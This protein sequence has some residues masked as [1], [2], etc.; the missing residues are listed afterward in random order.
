[1][2]V[3]SSQSL[4]PDGVGSQGKRAPMSPEGSRELP[5]AKRSRLPDFASATDAT[6]EWRATL[7]ELAPAIVALRVTGCRAF[8][9]DAAAS[10]L[11]T[12]FVVDKERGLILT[13]R[14]V[15]GVGPVRALAIFDRHE[16]L[17]VEVIYRDPVHDFGFFRFDPSKLRMTRRHEVKLDPKGLLVGTE[18]R[19][20]GN[21]AGEKLQILSGT[22]ARVDRN[23]PEF[24]TAYNDE[25]TFYAGAGAGTSG[26]SSGS[27]VVNKQGDAIALNAAGQEG[28]AAAYF[29]PLDRVVYTLALLQADKA[30]PRGTIMA[31]F[32]FQ[33]FD[34]LKRLGLQHQAE[35]E[36]REA[37]SAATGMLIAYSVACEQTLLRSGD[38]LLRLQDQICDNFVQLESVLDAHVGQTVKLRVC[39]L[40][41]E[42]DL[43]VPVRDFHALTPRS[44][45]ELGLDVVH[46]IGYHVAKKVHLPLDSGVYLA[47]SGYVFDSLGCGRASIIV[48]VNEKPTP[49]LK[50]FVEAFSTIADRECFPVTWYE[51]ADFRRD[52][53]LRTGFAKMSRSWSPM[54]LWHCCGSP[55]RP[56][57][58]SPT[59]L[60]VPTN[61]KRPTVAGPSAYF[62]T[63]AAPVLRKLQGSLVTVR[64]R[65]DRRFCTEAGLAGS[66]EGVGLIVDA[67]KGLVLTDRHSAPQSLG[68]VE[69][70]LAG[71]TTVDA[72]VVFIHPLHN[73]AILRYD[74]ASLKKAKL[75]VQSAKLSKGAKAFLRPGEN[76]FFAGYDSQGNSFAA[77]VTV[78]AVYLPSGRDE[79][80]MWD[81]P[82]FR[83]KNLEIAVLADTPED[84]RG[85][86]LCDAD[87]AVR[88]VFAAFDWQG[89]Q[90]EETTEAFGIP[91]A[92]YLPLV[93]AVCSKPEEALKVYSL[94]VE[95]NGLDISTLCRGASKPLPEEWLQALGKRCG[96]LGQVAR[97]MRIQRI[98]PG[99]ASHKLLKTGDVL[100]SVDGHAVACGLDI[101]TALRLGPPT[102]SS[103][104]SSRRK[105]SATSAAK[106]RPASVA[107]STAPETAAVS[108]GA[109]KTVEIQ[110]FR[111][112][113]VQTVSV[114]PVLLGSDCGERLL[115]WSGL[116]LRPTPRCIL[117]RCGES[118]ASRATG[119][120]AQ[121]VIGG[122]PADA[123]DFLVH[124][125]MLELDGRPI[126]N[127]EDVLEAIRAREARG[128]DTG[129]RSW[130][131]LRFMDFYGQEHVA[132]LQ[133][134][135]LF[136]PTLEL[137]PGEGGRRWTC[138]QI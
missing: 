40:G 47:R 39:R 121:N 114:P 76:V 21:D 24:A 91:V 103:S 22:I 93:E 11:G 112:G 73:I 125:F 61:T 30:V 129:E 67:D 49:T 46:G 77:P 59:I 19:V 79:F 44:F 69:V 107:S 110:L 3:N 75:P 42:H 1:M 102:A 104:S 48:S 98:L 7:S 130:V 137:R 2:A 86:I 16:E 28:A 117:E 66:S 119:V 82:R 37:H 41:K 62:S 26:G 18:I 65:T 123:R 51:L 127:L 27:P 38:I 89:S 94:D 136:F 131:H 99:G 133:P 92:V 53:S 97:A 90:R 29:V 132:A 135:P 96:Q 20:V 128:N 57:T 43:E 111:D 87:G 9:E 5:A 100:L 55:G 17:E 35:L 81:V 80:P 63:G 45:L 138:Q 70:T 106:K 116:C 58:W 95:V 88:A 122:S 78:S 56:E 31:A 83:E 118:V 101:E 126:K 15:A 108:G 8:E 52:R 50:D 10:S 60:P 115:I 72:E 124:W 68:D 74:A 120:F 85:G 4:S 33:P 134:D 25:N 71:T 105:S 113:V 32:L 23:V 34:E 36:V 54:K 109:G 64:F 6:G 14:H 13:N 84:A 12:G